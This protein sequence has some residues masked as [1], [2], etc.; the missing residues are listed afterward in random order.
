MFIG[1]SYLEKKENNA[2]VCEWVKRQKIHAIEHFWTIKKLLIHSTSKAN[3]QRDML[4]G[5][6]ANA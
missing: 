2:D 6:K 3:F 4:S 1:L 5:K